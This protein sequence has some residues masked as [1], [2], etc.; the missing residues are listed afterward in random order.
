MLKRN[1][2]WLP[3]LLPP[4]SIYNRIFLKDSTFQEAAYS[5]VDL[6]E[7]Y[8]LNPEDIINGTFKDLN[9]GICHKSENKLTFKEVLIIAEAARKSHYFDRHVQWLQSAVLLAENQRLIKKLQKDIK[10]AKSVHDKA[11]ESSL[12][13]ITPIFISMFS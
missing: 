9:S 6:Q 3:K 1:V 12:V 2:E 13:S 10:K 11:Y 5:I 4:D 7:F 8:D